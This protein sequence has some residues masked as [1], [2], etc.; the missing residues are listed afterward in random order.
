[1][2]AAPTLTLIRFGILLPFAFLMAA[3]LSAESR[4]YEAGASSEG[5]EDRSAADSW[6]LMMPRD[7]RD[8]SR[9]FE[10]GRG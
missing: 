8:P 4:T 2:P 1:M 10:V 6:M 3:L 9:G 5:E 7:G